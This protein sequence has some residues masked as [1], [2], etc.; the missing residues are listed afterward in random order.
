MVVDSIAQ[1]SYGSSRVRFASFYWLERNSFPD[2]RV[3]TWNWRKQTYKLEIRFYNDIGFSSS[4]WNAQD[5]NLAIYEQPQLGIPSPRE[6][7]FSATSKKSF[8][9]THSAFPLLSC[10]SFH[11]TNNPTKSSSRIVPEH[12]FFVRSESLCHHQGSTAGLH[13]HATQLHGTLHELRAR[14]FGRRNL[15]P[16]DW[17]RSGNG[18]CQGYGCLR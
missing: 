2:G 10:R 14:H 9:I 16:K 12:A 1:V 7:N 13:C 15:H 11:E 6:I 8:D 3:R 18:Q 17:S 4:S 5:G